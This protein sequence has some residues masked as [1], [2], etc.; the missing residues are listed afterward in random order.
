ML[1][2]TCW[3][4]NQRGNRRTAFL[5]EEFGE[6]ELPYFVQLIPDLQKL[7]VRDMGEPW[8][9]ETALSQGEHKKN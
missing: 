8:I 7:L 5:R 2:V 9:R 1:S 6:C 4:D 3:I